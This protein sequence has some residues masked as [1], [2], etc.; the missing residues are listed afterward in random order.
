MK[1]KQVVK[2]RSTLDNSSRKKQVAK[3][4]ISPP[5]IRNLFSFLKLCKKADS[6]TQPFK[7]ASISEINTLVKIIKLVLRERLPIKK[8]KL[9][10][11][12]K[13]K[14]IF[15]KLAQTRNN[16][17]LVKRRLINQTGGGLLSLLPVIGGLLTSIFTR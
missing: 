14:M 1:R 5:E 15:R 11:L 16:D 9:K 2:H 13:Y 3:H 12:K 10:K 8:D 17:N 6:R 7:N 4:L